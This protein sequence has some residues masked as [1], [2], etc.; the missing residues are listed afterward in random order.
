MF[1]DVRSKKIILVAHCLL[2][3]NSISDG[4]AD[5][6]SQFAEVVGLLMASRIGIVQLSCPEML[7][8]G[9]DR[10]DRQG[11]QRPLLEENTRIRR[12]M[13][14]PGSLARLRAKAEEVTVQV[15]EYRSNGFEVLGLVG[16]NRSP[17]CGVETT[18]REGRE[19]AGTGV[20]MEVLSQILLH[21]GPPVRMLGVKTSQ[22]QESVGRLRQFVEEYV[23]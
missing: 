21:A 23:S 18:T 15:Q 13:S 22:A 11:G 5:C 9:L 14:E 2:N 16:V 12:L 17:S 19:E 20:F 6:P 8:L 3:Q 4:T 10:R 1:D 7:C